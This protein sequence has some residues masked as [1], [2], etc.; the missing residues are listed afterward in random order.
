MMDT[1]NDENNNN[2]H[3]SILNISSPIKRMNTKR[4]F[5]E[6]TENRNC[7]RKKM[8]NL[9]FNND[10]KMVDTKLFD[11][12][13]RFLLNIRSINGNVNQI[14][15]S[16]YDSILS[17]KKKLRPLIGL[18]HTEIQLIYM[19]IVLNDFVTLLDK[20]ITQKSLLHV[21]VNLRG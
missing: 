16:P 9:F 10:N 11:K 7:K 1:S 15:V 19:G 5:N 20:N 3:S 21:I 6:N 2:I 8:E 17:V 4:D 13:N 12:E 18:E 14:T